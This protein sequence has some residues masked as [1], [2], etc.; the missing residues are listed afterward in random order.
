MDHLCIFMRLNFDES[1]IH[2]ILGLVLLYSCRFCKCLHLLQ[3]ERRMSLITL[4]PS[5]LHDL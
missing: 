5:P 2:C 3:L 1:A 4:T